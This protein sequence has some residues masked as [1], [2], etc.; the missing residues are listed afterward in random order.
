MISKAVHRP[1]NR[2]NSSDAWR[3]A[4]ALRF[5]LPAESFGD[6]LVRQP[7]WVVRR[8]HLPGIPDNEVSRR[9]AVAFSGSSEFPMRQTDYA[10]D[11]RHRLPVAHPIKVV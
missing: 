10:S 11:V 8:E 7:F 1:P 9:L 3:L 4:L 5:H 6:D 2:G